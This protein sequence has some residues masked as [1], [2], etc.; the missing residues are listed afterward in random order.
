MS[1]F[2][3]TNSI[4]QGLKAGRF[5]LIYVRAKARTYLLVRLEQR[6][7]GNPGRDP[8]QDWV[9]GCC[10]TVALDHPGVLPRLALA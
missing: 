3:E 8:V 10:V 4:P 1:G 6:V 9:W 7:L 2:Q 5:C